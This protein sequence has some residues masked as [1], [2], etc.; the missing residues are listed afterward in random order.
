MLQPE[1]CLLYLL[2]SAVASG[3]TFLNVQSTPNDVFITHDGFFPTLEEVPG[4]LEW[5]LGCS[6]VPSLV[7][8]HRFG[9][10]LAAAVAPP[11]V[12]LEMLFPGGPAVWV[13]GDEIQVRQIETSKPPQIRIPVKRSWWRRIFCQGQSLVRRLRERG[14]YAP[15]DLVVDEVP[16]SGT[17]FG[18]AAV[19]ESG[20]MSAGSLATISI[21]AGVGN[22]LVFRDHHLLELQIPSRSIGCDWL[23]LPIKS[24]ATLSLSLFPAGTADSVPHAVRGRQVRACSAAL[25]LCALR[26][27]CNTE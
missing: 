17:E 19:T 15:L 14:R 7:A 5:A 12:G 1:D 24:R 18:K 22:P 23:A 4:M 3:A 8:R 26:A 20:W 6:D 21:G 25:A 2:Q 9:M 10:A 13:R 16:G 27:Q 11:G